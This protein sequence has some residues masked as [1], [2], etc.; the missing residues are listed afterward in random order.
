MRLSYL[1]GGEEKGVGRGGCGV[2]E[3][4]KF[5]V[6]STSVITDANI[7]TAE[8]QAS[9]HQVALGAEHD[10]VLRMPVG[11]SGAGRRGCRSPG[12]LG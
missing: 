1:G 12:W 7:R 6:P 2:V 11:S 8:K 3:G 5:C 9:V 4:K 10:T